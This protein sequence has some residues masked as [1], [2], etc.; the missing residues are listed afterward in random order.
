MRILFE[1]LFASLIFVG[2]FALLQ[3]LFN[4]KKSKK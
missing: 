3:Y 1:L 2:I 4:N